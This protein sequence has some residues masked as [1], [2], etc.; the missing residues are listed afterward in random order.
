MR[1]ILDNEP[2]TIEAENLG[3]AL[4]AASDLAEGRGRLVVEVLVD[5][6]LLSDA[7]LQ[8]ESLLCSTAGEIELKTTTAAALLR[9]TFIQAAESIRDT[10]RIQENAAELLRS[11][12]PSQG[13]QAIGTALASWGEIHEAAVKGLLLAGE[14]PENLVVRQIPFEEANSALQQQLGELQRGIEAQDAS[15]ICDCLL[16][17]FPKVCEIWIEVL[18]GMAT[19][20]DQRKP[21][22]FQG[23]E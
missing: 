4:A 3:E 8:E 21:G 17:E 9:E 7:Q 20:Y 13:M 15:S 2:C 22:Q 5:G 23:D 18:Q 16:Y 10:A 14:D 11:G 1:V 12:Q 6:T 19:R